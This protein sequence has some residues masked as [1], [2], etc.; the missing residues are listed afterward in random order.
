MRIA[1]PHVHWG[2]LDS[3][4]LHTRSALARALRVAMVTAARIQML[5]QVN[6]R[7]ERSQLLV[8]PGATI[9]QLA[10]F[11]SMVLPHALHAP[12]DSIPTVVLRPMDALRVCQDG[13]SPAL[14]QRGILQ[15]VCLSVKRAQMAAIA[16][17]QEA[18]VAMHAHPGIIN[19]CQVCTSVVCVLWAAPALSR[20]AWVQCSG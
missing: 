18:I 13:T 17:F 1:P 4:A 11:P 16:P 10:N 8:Q 9:A 15:M 20:T 14:Q 5:A 3:K 7:L 2:V 6:V 12:L 19:R